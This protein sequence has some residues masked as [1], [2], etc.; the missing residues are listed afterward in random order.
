MKKNKKNEELQSRRAFFKKAA[1]GAL[2]ILAAAV[3]A[4]A[5]SIL[6]AAENTPSGCNYSLGME[7][8]GCTNANSED[9]SHLLRL[10]PLIN[11]R[12]RNL[13]NPTEVDYTN[14]YHYT[15]VNPTTESYCIDGYWGDWIKTIDSRKWLLWEDKYD[16]LEYHSMCH[17]S[18]YSMRISDL[19]EIFSFDTKSNIDK[20]GWEKYAGT[21]EYYVTDEYPDIRSILLSRQTWISPYFHDVSKGQTPCVKRTADAIIKIKKELKNGYDDWL[22]KIKYYTITYNVWFENVGY[23]ICFNIRWS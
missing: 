4:G 21:I 19:D 10:K 1:K 22:N 20:D 2:P 11:Y 12:N 15:I 18:Q 5:P 7:C 14:N 17:P 16:I 9:C 8:L 6:K 3:L 23:A 13:A